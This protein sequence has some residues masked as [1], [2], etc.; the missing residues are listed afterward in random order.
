MTMAHT[1]GWAR[2]SFTGPDGDETFQTSPSLEH[3]GLD[4]P[5]LGGLLV[6]GQNAT[7]DV[8]DKISRDP[9]L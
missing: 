1:L 4:P 2:F 5:F 8:S 7:D 9:A 3:G 6:L